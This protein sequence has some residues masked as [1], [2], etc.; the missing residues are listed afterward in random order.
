M[1]EAGEL[2][3]APMA[4]QLFAKGLQEDV[5]FAATGY[6]HAYATQRR[7]KVLLGPE[8]DIEPYQWPIDLN[9]KRLV[10]LATST[11]LGDTLWL[12]PCLRKL[13]QAFPHMHM[14]IVTTPKAAPHYPRMGIQYD[15][16]MAVPLRAAEFPAGDY[17]WPIMS[18]YIFEEHH[19]GSPVGAIA[20][21]IGM[22][23]EDV[24]LR[25]DCTVAE[26][27]MA[28]RLF[29]GNARPKVMVHELE[30]GASVRRYD[31]MAEVVALLTQRDWGVVR[32]V[33]CLSV[34]FMVALME[35]M[36]LFIGYDSG[37]LNITPVV[38]LKAIGLYGPMGA[39]GRTADYPNV[40]PI[41]A[42]DDCS[43]C[44]NNSGCERTKTTT[45]AAL[46][47]IPP[48]A[49]VDKAMEVLKCSTITAAPAAADAKSATSPSPIATSKPASAGRRSK[50]SRTTA[51][52]TSGRTRD[53]ARKAVTAAGVTPATSAQPTS[54]TA[55][56]VMPR[57][58]QATQTGSDGDERRIAEV[59]HA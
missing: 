21:T 15:A 14:T 44:W 20:A 32:V 3:G 9:G 12:G 28:T 50:G 42:P 19:E 35:R 23:V 33:T 39:T 29:E 26:R 47:A 41:Q 59:A 56:I 38:G 40:I 22:L 52:S 51:K 46:N 8:H 24:S 5:M 7:G 45:C 48:S 36:E 6:G 43:P 53:R 49:I 30:A 31:R 25:Y 54:T 55:S 13:R 58:L 16:L 17:L 18:G 4:W 57:S 1:S 10:V 34:G 27:Q 2:S 37:P 11:Q